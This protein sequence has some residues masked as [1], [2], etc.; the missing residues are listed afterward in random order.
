MKV[1][2]MP[3]S[4]I[5]VPQHLPRAQVRALADAVQAGLVSTCKVPVDDHFQLV[6]RFAADDM[7]LNPTFG[8]MARTLDASVVEIIFLQGRTGD[9][10]RAL[11]RCVTDLAVAAGFKA[12]DIMIALSEN[13]AIDWTLGRGL[14]FQGHS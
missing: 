11:Y 5:S 14:A 3:L 13:A 7:I 8:G 12:D 6:T 9:Q 10:K 1:L 2:T 4:R